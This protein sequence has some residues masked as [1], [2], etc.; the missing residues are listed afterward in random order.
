MPRTAR[1]AAARRV[2]R[3]AGALLVALAMLGATACTSSSDEP[4]DSSSTSVS[5][6]ASEGGSGGTEPSGGG[7]E[8]AGSTEGSGSSGADGSAS[9][10]L[11]DPTPT[12]TALVPPGDIVVLTGPMPATA[13]AT[14]RLVDGYPSSIV[15][16]LDEITVVSSS[17]SSQG[18]RL[19]LGLQGSSDL[20]PDEVTAAYVAALAAQSF[21][22]APGV[23]IEGSTATQFSRGSD[24]VVLTV[25]SRTGGGTELTL[26]GTL[27]RG[28]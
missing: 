10:T 21:S 1:T 18:D 11:P 19:Q 4:T 7:T 9:E 16:V 22:S 3:P 26:A 25:R 5:S 2:D 23:A 6:G 28:G 13:S 12:A 17:V 14:G 8:G 15:P 20:S 27:V 24:G